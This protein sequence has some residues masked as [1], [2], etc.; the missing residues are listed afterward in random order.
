[1]PA[2]S[3]AVR[4]RGTGCSNRERSGGEARS[5]SLIAEAEI[6]EDTDSGRVG[7]G[8][9]VRQGKFSATD[10]YGF[11]VSGLRAWCG[12]DRR[13]RDQLRAR[14]LLA[15]TMGGCRAQG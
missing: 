2:T 9:L 13:R 5:V 8:R 1:V 11:S 14:N 12:H 4:Y 3:G 6:R 7:A 15:C 10:G